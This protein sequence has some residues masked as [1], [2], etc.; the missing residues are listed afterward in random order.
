MSHKKTKR[1]HDFKKWKKKTQ[2]GGSFFLCDKYQKWGALLFSLSKHKHIFHAQREERREEEEKKKR[3]RRRRRRR[4]RDFD[5]D[6]NYRLRCVIL[7]FLNLKLIKGR[8]LKDL[9]LNL[10]IP[11]K[12]ETM[13]LMF[14][15]FDRFEN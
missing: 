7:I 9:C 15:G 5:F 14:L 12:V 1:R 13:N 3:M 8:Y 10:R 4:K 2:K 6:F 11:L